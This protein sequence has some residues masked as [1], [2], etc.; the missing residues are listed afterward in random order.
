M[1]FF[2]FRHAE[3]SRGTDNNPLLSPAG[4]QQAEALLKLVKDGKLPQPQ[5][6]WVSPK[7]RTH[8]TFAPLSRHF[9]IS[10][11]QREELEERQPHESNSEFRERIRSLVEEI[12][13]SELKNSSDCVF[14]CSHMD[15]TE[16]AMSIIPCD[17]NLTSGEYSYWAPAQYLGFQRQG[18]L[19]ELIQ[20]G[21]VSKPST[22]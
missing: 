16:Q 19:F 13:Q 14:M 17:T 1:T 2:L 22:F 6:L 15:W 20:A 4:L 8:Q 7:V 21:A 5:R 18:P 11:E 12:S 9:K 10:L 3:K